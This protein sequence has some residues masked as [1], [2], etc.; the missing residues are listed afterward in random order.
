MVLNWLF[1]CRCHTLAYV[2]TRGRIYAFGL[3]GNG[4]LGT[5]HIKNLCSPTLVN[6]PWV[7]HSKDVT[8]SEKPWYRPISRLSRQLSQIEVASDLEETTS[9]EKMDCGSSISKRN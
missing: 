2:P 1:N 8:L 4:Q 5:G 9:Q 6:G 7:H 3:G